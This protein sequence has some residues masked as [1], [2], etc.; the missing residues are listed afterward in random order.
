VI[1][2]NFRTAHEATYAADAAIE[3]SL[4]DL[5]AES[6]WT[7]VLA[8]AM[9]SEFVDG[10]PSGRRTLVDGSTIDLDQITNLANC[11]KPT[12]C[13]A[14]E[15]EAT[16][17]E[18]PWGANNPR[19]MLY[20]YGPL[21][22]LLDAPPTVRSAFYVVAFVGDDPSENDGDPTRDG[23]ST[24]GH[25]NPGEGIAV[26]RAEAFGPR[27]AHKVIEATVARHVLPPSA[28]GEQT[29]TELRVLSWIE[30]R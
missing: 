7:P 5:R 20:A 14:V 15:V 24:V 9:Q 2:G 29:S 11:Q 16:T 18:R 21:A 4:A 10:L 6:D 19:W 26:I 25:P 22:N 27:N 3:R 12:R 17:T 23:V 8:G 1:A 13:S 30:V 28:P